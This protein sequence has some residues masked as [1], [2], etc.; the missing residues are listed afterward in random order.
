MEFTRTV[1]YMTVTAT[2]VNKNNKK[3]EQTDFIIDHEI[4]DEEKLEKAVKSLIPS[5]FAFVSIDKVEH[6]KEIRAIPY[7]DFIRNSKVIT[8]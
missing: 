3:I 5:G 6:Y 7:A 2:L 8:R 4:K 1:K